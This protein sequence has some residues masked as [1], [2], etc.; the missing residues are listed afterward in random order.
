MKRFPKRDEITP[1]DF[2]LTVKAWFDSFAES[3]DDFSSQHLESVNGMDGDFEFDVTIR[4]TAFGGAK[5]LVVC[6]CKKHRN[7]IKREVVQALKAKKES[8]GAQKAF[9]IATASF[10]SGAEEY[11]KKHGIALCEIVS[12][13]IA[14]IQNKAFRTMPEIPEDADSYVGLFPCRMADGSIYP[15]ALIASSRTYWLE[16]Y[17]QMPSGKEYAGN[18]T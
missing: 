10:Q 1:E 16:E 4:F 13:S 5:F 7:P 15:I 11:A 9:V 3:L 14:Y 12:G 8:V 18:A 17:L 2:E 6:E